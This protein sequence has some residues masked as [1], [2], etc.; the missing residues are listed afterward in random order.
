MRRV[1]VLNVVGLTPQ[2]IGDHT[3]NLKQFAE[4]GAE[5]ALNTVVP[6]VTCSVQATFATGTLPRDHGI[7]ANGWYFRDLSEVWLWR[8][9][10]KLVSGEKIWDAAKKRDSSFTCAKLFW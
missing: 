4:R 2:L 6:A 9:S 7:V 5:R 10:N 8:Q 3:P 1:V